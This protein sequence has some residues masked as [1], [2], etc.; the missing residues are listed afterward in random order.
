MEEAADEAKKLLGIVQTAEA[1]DTRGRVMSLRPSHPIAPFA[2]ELAVRCSAWTRTTHAVIEDAIAEVDKDSMC[3]RF[4]DPAFGSE[5]AMFADET[6]LW[7]FKK[8]KPLDARA[9]D[10]EAYCTR[11]NIRGFAKMIIECASM[12][13][14]NA[15]GAKRYADAV[16]AR[17][18]EL[19]L[20]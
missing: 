8:G 1:L 3:L 13:H 6:L 18:R 15:D 17:V 12:G 10:R 2:Y 14:P 5:H 9:T 19:R 16:I 7:R 4:A 11:H 20:F